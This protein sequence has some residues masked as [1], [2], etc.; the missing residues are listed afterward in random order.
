MYNVKVTHFARASLRRTFDVPFPAVNFCVPLPLSFC[1]LFRVHFSAPFPVIVSAP[2]PANFFE[3]FRLLFLLG[4]RR[5]LVVNAKHLQT[6]WFVEALEKARLVNEH[7][8]VRLVYEQSLVDPQGYQLL[9]LVN[10]QVH[11]RLEAP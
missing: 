6:S 3:Q 9:S 1:V 5:G 7:Q 11:Q 2:F 4:G 8:L 10:Q